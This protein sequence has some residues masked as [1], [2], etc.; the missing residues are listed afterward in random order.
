MPP[1]DTVEVNRDDLQALIDG[2]NCLIEGNALQLDDWLEEYGM[3][4][5]EFD[6]HLKRIGKA[7]GM[8]LGIL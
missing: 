6:G 3:S 2:F 8:D 5:K 4:E 7:A 1:R